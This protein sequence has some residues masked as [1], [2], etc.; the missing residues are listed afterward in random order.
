M[1][2]ESRYL[3][4]SDIKS[5]HHYIWAYYLKQW[6]VNNRDVWYTTSKNNIALDSVYGIAWEKDFY[7]INFLDRQDVDFIK[8]FTRG[9]DPELTELHSG[10]INDFVLMSN[11]HAY[12]KRFKP[13]KELQQEFKEFQ[14][15]VLENLYGSHEN[16][17]LKVIQNLKEGRIEVL[18]DS[19]NRI[20]FFHFIAMQITKT[21][22]FQKSLNTTFED[23]ERFE[24]IPDKPYSHSEY[25]RLMIKN[26][27]LLSYL[28]GINIGFSLMGSFELNKHVLLRNNTEEGFITSDK[29]VINVHSSVLHSK[30]INS[31]P[32]SADFYY[33]I[34]PNYAYL[35]YGDGIVKD[36]VI[37]L[38]LGEVQAYNN[39]M[40]QSKTAHI[41]A[42][43]EA[44]IRT[45]KQ[46]R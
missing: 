12:S 40:Y 4:M 10:Y 45:I 22:N 35:I 27:W 41:F 37:D 16:D 15:N 44:L 23:K 34:S 32:Q 6:S 5:K 25:K 7:K 29:P 20:N 42:S 14:H 1:T 13:R 11:I 33:P 8:L 30:V 17:V 18:N 3:N 2:L 43:S 31:A 24:A 38:S 36:R 21:K 46:R 39:K 28:I 19:Q 9:A 26:R